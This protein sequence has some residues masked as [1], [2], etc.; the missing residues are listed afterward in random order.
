LIFGG[1]AAILYEAFFRGG[2]MARSY[3]NSRIGTFETCPRQYK[4]EYIEKASVEKPVGVELFLGNAVH[5]VLE[6]LYTLKRNGRIQSLE[7]VLAFYHECWEGP[8]IDKIKVTRE[9]LGVD[10]YIKVGAEALKKYYETMQ[11][12]DDGEV[13]ALEKNINFPLDPNGR[14]SISGR[15]DRISRDKDGLVEIIDYKTKTSLPSQQVFDNDDQMGLY[16]MGVRYSWPDFQ[17]IRLKQYFLRQGVTMM[18]T[19]DEERLEEIRYR[20]Y[21]KIL[22]IEKAQEEDNFPPKEGAICDWCVYFELCPAKRH[23]LTLEGDIAVEFDAKMG[24][25]MAGKYLKLNS[26]KKIIESELRALKQDIVKYCEETDITNIMGDTGSLTLHVKEGEAFPSK[27]VDEEAFLAISQLAREAGLDES[28]KLD[29]NVLYKE[30]YI[31]ER[32]PEDLKERLKKYL[33]K[34]RQETLRTYY[35]KQ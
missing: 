27:S 12:F 29:E 9:G 7:E 6:K 23:R 14:F 16:Q 15:V 17:N 31:K 8:D 30:F 13:I 22:E 34:K 11:P 10:D 1:E 20:T 25:E 5:R 33:I 28:F 19:M 35:K 21:Q 32:L 4:F 2:V 24:Q 26:D 18:T 3:S